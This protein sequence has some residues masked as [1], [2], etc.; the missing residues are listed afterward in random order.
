MFYPPPGNESV[1]VIK[2]KNVYE[3]FKIRP[4]SMDA[5]KVQT[6]EKPLQAICICLSGALIAPVLLSAM[7]MRSSLA[8]KNFYSASL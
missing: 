2:A 3:K 6:L 5:S 7:F 8:Y 4:S 1:T